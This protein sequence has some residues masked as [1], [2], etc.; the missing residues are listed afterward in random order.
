MAH[1][2]ERVVPGIAL[3]NHD[4]QFQLDR[5]IELLLKQARLF[6]L[7]R[8]V[9]DA[10]FDLVVRFGLERVEITCVLFSRATVALGR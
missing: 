3:M 1:H 9:V 5:E 8:A 6:A 7:E 10:A 2:L 4:V